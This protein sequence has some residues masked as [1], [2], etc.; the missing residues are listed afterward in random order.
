MEII[1]KRSSSIWKSTSTNTLINFRMTWI[2]S[3]NRSKLLKIKIA[4]NLKSK[5]KQIPKK[6]NLIINGQYH[7]TILHLSEWFQTLTRS[8]RSTKSIARVS[9]VVKCYPFHNR[10]LKTKTIST[11]RVLPRDSIS[12][13]ILERRKVP[14]TRSQSNSICLMTRWQSQRSAEVQAETFL[15]NATKRARLATRH[16]EAGFQIWASI[17]MSSWSSRG[18]P[19]KTIPKH[20]D[21]TTMASNQ[22]IIR[23]SIRDSKL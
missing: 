10:R 2:K 15:K 5:I 1:F 21:L 6:S 19:R 18:K 9:R 16:K 17:T 3:L 4:R 23:D 11:P 7:I 12:I 14:Q 13:Q 8:I 20:M 22:G